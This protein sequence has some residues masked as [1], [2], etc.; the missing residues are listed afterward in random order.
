MLASLVKLCCAHH[1]V[2]APFFAAAMTRSSPAP[3]KKGPRFGADGN[4]EIIPTVTRARIYPSVLLARILSQ[5]ATT[6][7][8]SSPSFSYLGTVGLVRG[9]S[10]LFKYS[11]AHGHSASNEAN[12]P[13][14]TFA[15]VDVLLL[16]PV[17]RDPVSPRI[18]TKPSAVRQLP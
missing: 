3:R 11:S 14:S 9:S 16:A 15:A 13:P 7:R 5:A 2:G 12:S 17:L 1:D 6:P 8:S 10:V 4:R 18:P